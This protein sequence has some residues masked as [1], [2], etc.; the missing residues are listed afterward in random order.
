MNAVE[1]VECDRHNN[2]QFF[3]GYGK[4][5]EKIVAFCMGCS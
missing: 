3:M 5:A 2:F 4:C 1:S